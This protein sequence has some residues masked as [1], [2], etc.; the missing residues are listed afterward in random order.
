M[1]WNTKVK[2]HFIKHIY[3]IAQA[4]QQDKS[5]LILLH[6]LDAFVENSFM[7]M[8]IFLVSVFSLNEQFFY[9]YLNMI[10]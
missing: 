4:M 1:C 10:L 8:G 6:H 5:S 3:A 9:F 2:S 7:C